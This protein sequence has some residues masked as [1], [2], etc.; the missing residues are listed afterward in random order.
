MQQK[1]EFQL[2]LEMKKS[3]AVSDESKLYHPKNERLVSEK[4]ASIDDFITML[5]SLVAKK[6][7]MKKLK[8]SL[9]PD[10]G[11][12]LRVDQAEK[13][14]HPYI[15]YRIISC[16]HKQG[17]EIKPR[18]RQ[19]G[20]IEKMDGN[21]KTTGRTGEVWGQIFDY[22]VQ[23]DI[24]ASDYKTVTEVMNIFEDMLFTYAAHFMLEG[25]KGIRFS[26]RLTDSNLDAYRQKCSVRSLVYNI[27]IEK[28]TA[29]YDLDIQTF[30]V[31]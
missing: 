18:L 6:K 16:S 14:E 1:D 26:S 23:F 15:F 12:R 7:E 8:V 20:F 22:I 10:E 27:D 30:N 13:L 17:W 25:V 28:L 29:R 21:N 2:M 3:G 19:T 11:I 5:A 24:L 4:S 31:S 9:E